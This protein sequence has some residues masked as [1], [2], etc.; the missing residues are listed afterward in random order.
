MSTSYTRQHE[1]KLSTNLTSG[2]WGDW[3][4]NIYLTVFKEAVE[5]ETAV[6]FP[7][8]SPFWMS[9]TRGMACFTASLWTA[10]PSKNNTPL[11]NTWASSSLRWKTFS[12]EALLLSPLMHT[13][14]KNWFL[15]TEKYLHP[16]QANRSPTDAFE[17]TEDAL[18]TLQ[19]PCPITYQLFNKEWYFHLL[20]AFK[21][22]PRK[23]QVAD[24]YMAYIPLI[25]RKSFSAD[26]PK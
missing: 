8:S 15:L 23:A 12:F 14:I 3:Q 11:H 21:F 6:T 16:R 5:K 20:L 9:Q 17:N 25:T 19:S 1:S 18:T 7:H 26:D 13:L 22:L 2:E 10:L 24:C 4:D